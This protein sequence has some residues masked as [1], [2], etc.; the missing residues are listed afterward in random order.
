MPQVKR[1]TFP[2]IRVQW[3]KENI[4]A[5]NSLSRQLVVHSQ[6]GKIVFKSLAKN[7]SSTKSATRI[8]INCIYRET[9]I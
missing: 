1:I 6:S 8:R 5:N 4:Y 9:C 3:G 2:V 7:E